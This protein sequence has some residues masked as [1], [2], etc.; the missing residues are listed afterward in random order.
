MLAGAVWSI[1]LSGYLADP[2][3]GTR[4]GFGLALVLPSLA[5]I[6][7]PGRRGVVAPLALLVVAVLVGASAVPTLLERARPSAPTATAQELEEAVLKLDGHIRS[8]EGHRAR[9]QSDRERT[10]E[11]VRALGHESFEQISRDRQGMALL[12]ELAEIDRM[13]ADTDARLAQY[14]ERLSDLQT[15][16]R[17]LKRL[18][19]AESAGG[20]PASRAEIERILSEASG[21]V[22]PEGAKTVE[23]HIE[24]ERLRRLFEEERPGQTV[25]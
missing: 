11:A 16:V 13:V 20:A 25:R 6:L 1:A 9:L 7:R 5:A 8:A 15:A 2:S 3:A 22:E 14:R 4:L 10:S 12:E 18:A 24:R 19:S 21:T 17:R 23:K